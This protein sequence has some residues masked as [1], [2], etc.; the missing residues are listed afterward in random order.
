MIAVGL[1]GSEASSGPSSSI[2]TGSS[3]LS[4]SRLLNLSLVELVSE[5][6]NETGSGTLG[7][8][9]SSSGDL[10]SLSISSVII[11]SLV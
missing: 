9:Y 6:S 11:S 3:I 2:P 1:I 7:L 4:L 10:M 5:R 8:F